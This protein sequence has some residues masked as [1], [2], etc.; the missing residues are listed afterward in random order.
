[1]SSV[2]DQVNEMIYFGWRQKILVQKN[3]RRFRK[4]QRRVGIMTS[5]HVEALLL[6]SLAILESKGMENCCDLSLAE[7]TFVVVVRA[8]LLNLAGLDH[9]C[10]HELDRHQDSGS[11]NL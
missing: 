4:F 9:F 1:M 2:G 6:A 8:N 7:Q 5:H 11:L 3:F 10:R